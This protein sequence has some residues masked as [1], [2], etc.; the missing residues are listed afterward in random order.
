MGPMGPLSAESG[1]LGRLV[2]P[3]LP[4]IAEGIQNI[5]QGYMSCDTEY[6][7]ECSARRYPKSPWSRFFG[8][9]RP[10]CISTECEKNFD[11]LLDLKATICGARRALSM[12]GDS[13]AATA[14]SARR[15][16]AA[17]QLTSRPVP[18]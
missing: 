8:L 6:R 9:A 18:A 1:P 5:L 4:Y 13:E 15:T 2:R 17:T 7:A 12:Y 16:E 11:Q 10:C 14:S 3:T